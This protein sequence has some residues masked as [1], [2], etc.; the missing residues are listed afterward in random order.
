MVFWQLEVVEIAF[1]DD[2]LKE[3]IC[4]VLLRKQLFFRTGNVMYCVGD[5][6]PPT[7]VYLVPDKAFAV[8]TCFR[9]KRTAEERSFREFSVVEFDMLTALYCGVSDDPPTL[10]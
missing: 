10:H 5:R 3:F 2:F 8:G 7:A 1:A 6:Y 4:D 9:A